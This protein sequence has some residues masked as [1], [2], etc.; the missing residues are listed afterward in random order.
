M[1]NGGSVSEA[2]ITIDAIPAYN[3][4]PERLNYHPQGRDNGY[5]LG[6]DGARIYIGGDTEDIP[7]MR[8]LTDIDV[9]FLPME[10]RFTMDI[11]QAAAAIAAFK[12]GHVY[13]YHYGQADIDAFADLI[14]A[15]GSGTEVKRGG[16]YATS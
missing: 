13:P 15:G 6:V 9:A 1:A 11:N 16:W 8:A 12:P 5:V 14:K 10:G 2:G 4:T 3:T 7:E